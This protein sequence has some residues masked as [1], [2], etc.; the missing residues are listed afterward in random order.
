[1]LA[2]LNASLRKVDGT[3]L[4]TL[5]GY[6]PAQDL[7]PNSERYITGPAAC[8]SSFRPCR[9]RSLLFTTDSEA[10]LGV[11][12]SPKGDIDLAVFNYPTPQIAMERLIAFQNLPGAM[13]KRSGPLVAVTVAAAGPG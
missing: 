7:V 3:S 11:F 4:P 9:L 2:D 5:R 8:R 12:H 13:A 1:M 10:R 6:L